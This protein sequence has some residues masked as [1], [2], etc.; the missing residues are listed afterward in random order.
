MQPGT[1]GSGYDS[2]EVADIGESAI[3][4]APNPMPFKRHPSKSISLGL[5]PVRSTNDWPDTDIRLRA[6]S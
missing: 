6:K 3:G 2:D 1:A 5:I 4:M